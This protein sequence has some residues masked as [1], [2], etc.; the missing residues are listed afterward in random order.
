MHLPERCALGGRE[1]AAEEP[2]EVIGRRQVFDLPEP[3][4]EVTEHRLGC[5]E[6]GGQ[7]QCGTYPDTV[8]SA[9]QY[10]P[11]GQALVVNFRSITRCRWNRSVVCSATC[12]ATN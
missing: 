9:V 8:S 2:H 1:I 6:C 4:Q 3:K 5:I 7:K 10:G 12:T 11:G